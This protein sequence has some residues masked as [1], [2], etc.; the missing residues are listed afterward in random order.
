M[1]LKETLGT[2]G[3]DSGIAGSPETWGPRSRQSTTRDHC[4]LLLLQSHSLKLWSLVSSRAIYE[5]ESEGKERK[6]EI[7]RQRQRETEIERQRQA[8]RERETSVTLF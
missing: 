4:G 6:R 2:S 8:E 7:E 1:R 3:R 5:L